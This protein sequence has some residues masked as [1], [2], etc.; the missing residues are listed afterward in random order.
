MRKGAGDVALRR[1][2]GPLRASP[3]TPPPPAELVDLV[4][5]LARDLARLDVKEHRISVGGNGSL[6]D[7]ASTDR[8]GI[9][10]LRHDPEGDR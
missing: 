3:E 7:Q 6:D 1:R 2:G 10:V 5:A 8:G 9:R 4:K